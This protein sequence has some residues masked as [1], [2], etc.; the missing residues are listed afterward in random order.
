MGTAYCG[1]EERRDPE[2]T[3]LFIFLQT[4]I[5]TRQP[6]EDRGATMVEYALVVAGIAL[7]AMVAVGP[8]GTAI[9]NLFD[10][11]STK[12]VVTP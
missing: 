4:Y 9:H 3:K 6:H 11:A 2:M 1:I 5:A 7:V 10:T 12:V 8:L